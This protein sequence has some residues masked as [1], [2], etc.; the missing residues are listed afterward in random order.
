MSSSDDTTK[1]IAIVRQTCKGSRS[2][3]AKLAV[4]MADAADE[5]VEQ[6]A[7]AEQ[8]LQKVRRARGQAQQEA[9]EARRVLVDEADQAAR[10][11]D[12]VTSMV[13]ELVHRR[14]EPQDGFRCRGC[15]GP[16]P[17]PEEVLLGRIMQALENV[18]R[19]YKVDE[20]INGD[21][22]DR[23]GPFYTVARRRRP[24]RFA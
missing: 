17:E 16:P 10:A 1:S 2:N 20:S 7:R 8:D 6:L 19:T 11:V 9:E 22:S 13:R 3:Y 12:N 15:D 14:S 18:P 23:S 21:D 24:E 5:L 4:E